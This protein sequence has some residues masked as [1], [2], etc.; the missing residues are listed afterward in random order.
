MNY[1]VP[2][3]SYST[4]PYH[5]EVRINEFKQMIQALH[6]NGLGVI[7]DVVY[8]HTYTTDWCYERI[9]PGYC[10]RHNEDGTYS[11]GSECGNDVAS[12][13]AMIRKYLVDSIVYWAK[14]YHID[15]F[16][17]D[18]VGLI[19]VETMQAIRAALDKFNPNILLYGEGWSMPTSVSKADTKMSTQA[20]ASL[21]PGMGFFNDNIRD[22]IKG[23]VFEYTEKGYVTGATDQMD[24]IKDCILGTQSWAMNPTQV[25]NY[26]SCHDNNTLWDK[27]AI[28]NS[29]DSKEDRI[30]Q[31]LLS[32]AI[33]YTIPGTPLIQ[34]GEEMLRTKVDENGNFVSNSYKSSDYVN[35][36]KWDRYN[37]YKEVYEYYI[38][39]NAFRKEHASLRMSTKEEVNS[40]VDFLENLD[41][42]VIGYTITCNAS[43]EL[44]IVYNPN[45]VETTI[46]L[47]EGK[48]DV[49]IKDMTAGITVLSTVEGNVSVEP[50]SCMVLVKKTTK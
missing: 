30:R 26:T 10:F 23:S 32:A 24:T 48:W 25:I 13:R 20:N 33:I 15:G 1:N 8:N 50:I 42:N 14:E 21:L 31:N 35:S 43:E 4:D 36:I 47:P 39:L 18:L 19:D 38:G 49:Y 16:R 45:K 41:E 12:E 44:L 28:S 7:M 11:N 46:S 5:G 6:T 37:E 9:V 40:S 29:E 3:G 34:A 2:E 17:F 22:G 27:L